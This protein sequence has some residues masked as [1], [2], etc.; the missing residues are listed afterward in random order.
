MK[1]NDNIEFE[2]MEAFTS[3]KS[4]KDIGM[5]DIEQELALVKEKHGRRI[6][7]PMRKIAASVAIIMALGGITL[8]AVVNG[9]RLAQFFTGNKEMPAS[10]VTKTSVA[11]N[12]ELIIMPSDTVIVEKGD[13]TFDDSSLADIMTSISNNYNIN[14]EFN[15]KEQKAIRLHFKYNTSDSLE[16]V[17]KALNMFE[18][19]KVRHNNEK[20]EVE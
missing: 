12:N 3:E 17:V 19:I 4:D 5:P 20:L 16:D 9:D 10:A 6:F 13:I 15:N 11:R 14:V 1:Q 2:L 8:A 18:K 7:P